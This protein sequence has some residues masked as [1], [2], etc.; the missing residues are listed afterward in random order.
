MSP[1]GEQRPMLAGLASSLGLAAV[2][3]AVFALSFDA[4]GAVGELLVSVAR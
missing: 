1:R 2:I 4:I 3:T